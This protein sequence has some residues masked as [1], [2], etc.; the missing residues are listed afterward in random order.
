MRSVRFLFFCVVVSLLVSCG[1]SRKARIREARINTVINTARSYIGTPYKWGG[2]TRRGMDCS[3]LLINSFQAVD[4][5]LPRMSKA[6]SKV[7]KKIKR[8]KVK[9]GDLV[10]FATTKK[11]RK[12][13]HVGL[14][15]SVRG[16][17]VTAPLRWG[18]W[19]AI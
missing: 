8:D 13:T 19:K 14:V 3:G 4:Y 10:F 16:G 2:T 11:K 6:Q 12:V 7:G 17:K 5:N 15:T 9:P 1:A 18:W